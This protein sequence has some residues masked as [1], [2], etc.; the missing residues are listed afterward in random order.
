MDGRRYIKAHTYRRV[1]SVSWFGISC[2]D[3]WAASAGRAGPRRGRALAPVRDRSV[4]NFFLFQCEFLERGSLGANPSFPPCGSHLGGAADYWAPPA[5][6]IYAGPTQRNHAL[7]VVS[8][9]G[10]LV[11]WYP[12][13][14][15]WKLG[16]RASI[17]RDW[18]PAGI[19]RGEERERE[20]ANAEAPAASAP[21]LTATH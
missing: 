19:L 20:R 1:K 8:S 17:T 10:V 14:C 4:I 12:K 16:V 18:E 5:K 13:N 7:E 6:R 15:L 2:V 9:W 21:A 11:T 3:C